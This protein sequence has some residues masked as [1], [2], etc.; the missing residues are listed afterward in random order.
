M[1]KLQRLKKLR[2]Q[3]M[4]LQEKTER[5]EN[6]ENSEEEIVKIQEIQVKDQEKKYLERKDLSREPNFLVRNLTLN[7]R[8]DLKNLKYN[9]SFKKF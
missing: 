1:M 9:Q 5:E 4:D 3:E 6:K 7:H 8:T 2:S